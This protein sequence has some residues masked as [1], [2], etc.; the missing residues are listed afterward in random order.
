MKKIRVLLADDHTL[1]RRGLRLIVEQ[2]PDLVVGGAFGEGLTGRRGTVRPDE[3]G[4]IR[5]RTMNRLYYVKGSS[6]F[7]FLGLGFLAT[8]LDGDL[9]SILHRIFER[10]LDSEQAVLVGRF[11]FVRFHRPT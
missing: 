1:M 2:Q 8:C 3:S 6:D 4:V 10:H 11:G 5:G 7:D 9:H